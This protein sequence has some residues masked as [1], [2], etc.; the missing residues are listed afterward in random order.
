MIEMGVEYRIFGPPGCG[1]TTYL[2]KQ[3]KNAVEKRGPGEI[4]VASFTKAAASEL[5]GRELPINPN[6]IGT[7]HAHCFRAL[8]NK[9]IAETYINN[10][11]KYAPQFKMTPEKGNNHLD[12]PDMEGKV[13]YKG[14][15]LYLR[16]QTLRNKLTERRLWPPLVKAFAQKWENWKTHEMEVID[17]TDMIEIAY[18]N[19]ETPPGN[20]SIGFFD[21]VQD[22][23]PLELALVR[24]WSSKM[25]RVLL[26]GDDDQ[27]QPPSTK[28]LTTNGYKRID[29]LD[30]ETDRVVSYDRAGSYAVGF[31]KGYQFE[32]AER[33][34]FGLMYKIKCRN[35]VSKSTDNHKWLVKW[36]DKSTDMNC[37]YLMKKGNRFRVGWCQ[38]FRSDGCFHLG[39][40]TRLEK[41]DAVWIL[42]VFDNKSD[43]YKWETVISSIYGIPQ[44][45]FEPRNDSAGYMTK[46]NIDFVF[47]QLGDLTSNAK[48]CLSKFKRSIDYPFWS[49]ERASK[50][51]GG[52]SIMEIRAVNL[53]PGLMKIPCHV[54]GKKTEWSIIDDIDI[55]FYKGPVYSLNVHKHHKYIA[56]GLVTCNCIYHFKGA[57]PATFLNPPLP[58]DQI[59]ILNQSY[60][61]PEKVQKAAEKVVKKI[62]SRQEKEYKPR[63]NRETGEVIEGEYRNLSTGH[64]KEPEEVVKDSI[65]Y[66]EEGKT[67]MFLTACSYMLDPLKKILR[68][69]GLAYHNPYRFKRGDWNPLSPSR[70]VSASERLLTYL[71][72]LNEIWGD[73]ARMW[74]FDDLEKWIPLIS[75]KK[76]QYGAKKKLKKYMEDEELIKNVE[77]DVNDLLWFLTEESLIETLPPNL[78]WFEDNLLSSKKKSF[79][80][81]LEIAKNAGPKKLLEKPQVIIGTIH[82][83]KGGEADV[84]YLFPDLSISGM[85]EYIT[86]GL[87]KDS[88][89]RQFYVGMTRAKESLIITQPSS[90]NAV[91]LP[92]GVD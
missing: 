39:H 53:L 70:G 4:M 37:V 89:L 31:R 92:Q 34:Y 11:N 73:E 10:W 66:I 79:E 51:Q 36:A 78:G 13:Q 43:C 25:E 72:P 60:R 17:F 85:R 21:E 33:N 40:R 27:C 12:E 76:L 5:T 54:K 8:N 91:K 56:D 63:V 29:E 28:V 16:Y 48:R 30:P 86:P 88:I 9:R 42:K 80:F 74:T 1:K 19:I 59:R 2:T 62:S 52:T 68:K 23:T 6:Q 26:A 18:Q 35:K 65:K 32:K 15:E 3:I 22:F 61:V 45:T 24:K 49:P 82:S 41:A 46:E 7:L 75:S 38:L 58:E 81:P 57:D 87:P 50:Q 77:I 64:F 83:V 71:N 47:N 90:N 67:V 55:K 14:D 44:I 20:P 69:E 84:V